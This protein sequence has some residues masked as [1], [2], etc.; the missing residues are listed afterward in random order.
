M[1]G[2]NTPGSNCQNGTCLQSGVYGT[3]GVPA[4]GNIPGGRDFAA[5]W[6]DANGHLWLFGGSIPGMV[7]AYFDDLW[8][9]YPSTNEWAWMGGSSQL[10]QSGI[11]GNEGTPAAGNIPG[12]RSSMVSWT[13][14]SGDL[15]LFG[16]Q[17]YDSNA[18][19]GDFNDLWEF[20]PSTN[21]WAWIDGSST[22]SA[23]VYVPPGVYGTL[24]VPAPGNTPGG[25]QNASGWIDQS[26]N[27]WLFGGSGADAN[28]TLG[29]LNDLWRFGA[30]TSTP[31]AAAPTFM[32]PAGTY[33]SAQSVTIND[34][35]PNATIYYA[36]N[37]SPT[38]SSTQYTGPITVS[39]S[40]TVEAIA[41]A[42][43]YT[44][45]AVASAAYTINLPQPAATPTF[46]PP[47]GTYTSVQ[48]VTISDTTPNATIY[49][50]INATPTASS[51]Q[52]TGPITVS[53]SETVEAIAIAAGYTNSAVASAAYTINLPAP[54]FSLSVAPSSLTV[55]RGSQGT[56]TL[57]ITPQNGF[58]NELSFSCSGL[59]SGV[60]YSFSP[61]KAAPTNGPLNVL[62]TLDANQASAKVIDPH[63]AARMPALAFAALLGILG[64]RK[65][66]RWRML[67]VLAMA[68]PILLLSACDPKLLVF[69]PPVTSTVTVTATSVAMQQSANI[70]LT[71][72]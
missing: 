66:R 70:T 42:A 39:S 11:Y 17:G 19:P 33:T 69:S 7:L 4:A 40:E 71:V 49:Y 60:S 10:N 61:V 3:L 56:V 24:G 53:S 47:A 32:P 58:N 28:D 59:P 68:L 1:G 44:N 6:T 55:D 46:N 8:E 12:S 63:S 37:A 30:A 21:E 18:T 67:V 13:D 16:G 14:T 62:L 72:R 45:S 15:W 64:L 31:P 57:T 50:A 5:T 26:G 34:S 25:R 20:N 48:S 65:R 22:V 29:S 9:Y 2:S 52:Y 27:F 23:P 35:T 41:I 43:G 36:I 38:T 51:T 54:S